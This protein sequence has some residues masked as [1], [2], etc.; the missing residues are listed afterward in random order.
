MP[1][2]FWGAYLE[3]LVVL[4]LILA[5]LYLVARKL[6]DAR[7]LGGRQNHL[8]VLESTMLCQHAALHIVRIG[9]R[10]F[11]IGSSAGGV[12]ALAELSELDYTLK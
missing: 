11:L 12:R 7:G 4:A 6:R 1:W 10:F 5:G 3:K 9:E 8:R 2:A